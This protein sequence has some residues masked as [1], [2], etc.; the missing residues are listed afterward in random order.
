[1]SNKLKRMTFTVT[2]DV[3]ELMDEAKEMFCDRTRSDM[4]RTLVVAGLTAQK[5]EKC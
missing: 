1:M 4:I 3:E 5:E 2:P